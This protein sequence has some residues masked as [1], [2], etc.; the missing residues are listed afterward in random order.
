[1]PYARQ[2]RVC[3]PGQSFSLSVICKLLDSLGVMTIRLWDVHNVNLTLSLINDTTIFHTDASD[4]FARYKI[5]DDFDMTNLILCAPD[6]GASN[7]VMEIVNLFDLSM[8]VNIAKERCSESGEITELKFNKYN[9]SIDGYNVMIIDDIC[10]G[11][12][13]FLKAAK[14]LKDNGAENLY[15]YITHGIFSKGLD[16]LSQVFEHIICHHV[17][18]DDL[19]QSN[20][21]LTILREEK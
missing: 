1:L 4:I 5:F 13:T 19:Y 12:S 7:R 21:K 9:R 17:L 2:D 6:N 14:I 3:S 16:E 11:G 18:D 10:D 8:P 20:D 15:L